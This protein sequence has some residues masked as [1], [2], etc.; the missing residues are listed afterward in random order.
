MER[1]LVRL[2]ASRPGAWVYVNILTHI[3]RLILPA[4]RGHISTAVGT[5]FHRHIVIVTT[6]GA[7]TRKP[8]V[9]PLLALLDHSAVV[10]VASRGGHRRHPSWYH[11][12][13]AHPVATVMAHGQTKQYRAREAQAAERADL[14]RRVVEFY[15]GYA[16]YQRRTARRVP[17]MILE[18]LGEA[19]S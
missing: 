13:R 12:L 5:S 18:P 10:L 3:D 19:Q 1:A 17:V 9:V 6:T 7:R 2:A 15:P 11:N 16:A 14:W 8:R 4:T